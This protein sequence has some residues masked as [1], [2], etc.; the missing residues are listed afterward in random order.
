MSIIGHIELLIIQNHRNRISYFT[1]PFIIPKCLVIVILW[2]FSPSTIAPYVF[3]YICL[4]S[5]IQTRGCWAT[6]AST[7]PKIPQKDQNA[8]TKL[9]FLNK[10]HISHACPFGSTNYHRETLK[11]LILIILFIF[12][13]FNKLEDTRSR[14]IDL[15]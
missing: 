9:V 8:T 4:L 2:Q 12:Y 10:I 1:W 15:F 7:I 5:R 13:N 11:W 14:S 3:G 6:N